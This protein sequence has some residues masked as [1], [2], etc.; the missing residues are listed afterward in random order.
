MARAIYQ[1]AAKHFAGA[2]AALLPEPPRELVARAGDSSALLAWTAPEA[3]GGAP[4][5]YRV[6]RSPNGLAFDGGTP[7]AGT[8]L[9]VELVPGSLVFFRVTATN[10]GGESFPTPVAAVRAPLSDESPRVLVVNGYERLD[11]GLNAK[12]MESGALGIVDRQILDRRMNSFDYAAEHALALH[13]APFDL[14]VDS[15]TN[16]S[17]AD[18]SVPLGDY[19]A[20]DWFTGSEDA[21]HDTLTP[22]ERSR[23]QEYLAAGGNLL[24]SGSDIGTD[25]ATLSSAAARAF[26]TTWLKAD[27]AAEDA[28]SNEVRSASPGAFTSQEAFLLSDAGGPIRDAGLSDAL[29][30]LAA[31]ASALVYGGTAGGSAG[32]EFRGSYG[33]V[34]LGFPLE[35]IRLPGARELLAARAARFLVGA[36]GSP[37]IAMAAALPP[38]V[39]LEV[40]RAAAVLDGSASDDGDGGTQGLSFRW[41]KLEGP[42]GDR[43]DRPSG[44]E[45][46]ALPIGFGDGDDATILADM[47][48]GYMSVFLVREVEVGEAASI[49]GARLRV[50]H[51]D[52]F[53][54]YLNGVEIARVNLAPGAAHDA[55]AIAAIEPEE[56][57][58]DLVSRLDLFRDGRNLLA[59]EA[60]NAALD[61]SDLTLAA[62][63]QVETAEG[64]E[65]LVPPGASW[66]FHRGPSAPPAGWKAADF[67]LTPRATG[68]EVTRAG[69]YRYELEVEDG[70]DPPSTDTF[71]VG[72]TVLPEN[73]SEPFRRGDTDGGGAVDIS[74][75][76]LVLNWLFAGGTEPACTDAADSDDSGDVDI[77]DA[78]RILNW[79]FSGGV[80][81]ASPGPEAC[82]SDPTEDALAACA[83]PSGC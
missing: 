55:P 80:E 59:V 52:G 22:G 19:D 40:G 72:L 54:A 62:E 39:R 65:R 26:Y 37:P 3:G 69:V 21:A 2:G 43:I 45:R 33:L 23:I 9:E 27:V 77:T 53:A 25:L 70:E 7:A 15:S 14:G 35:A 68:V 30:P 44:W 10:A 71:E 4:T 5:G 74:D 75:A 11:A 76:V 28:E 58:I 38:L 36:P 18:G 81:P 51:D 17:V 42:A 34:H 47:R 64:I 32:I 49:G 13:A 66:F 57:V 78:V 79:L 8:S 63:L 46:G 50:L 12:V 6:Y 41:R 20:V 83:R 1:A 16:L 29:S 24:V 67:E 73:G 61:S 31:A 56:A 60:H 48:G 82:G